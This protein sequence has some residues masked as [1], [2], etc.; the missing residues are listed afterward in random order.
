[1]ADVFVSYSSLDSAIAQA[2]SRSLEEEGFSVWR[3]DQ[4]RSGVQYDA[5]IEQE[6]IGATCVVVIWTQNSIFSKWVRAEATIADRNNKL[7]A[8]R[9]GNFEL[10]PPFVL[11]QAPVVEFGSIS[12]AS[13]AVWQSGI[14]TA[15]REL[16]S[17]SIS[18]EGSR[19]H[20]SGVAELSDGRLIM[21]NID[22]KREFRYDAYIAYG[23]EDR[24][25]VRSLLSAIRGRLVGWDRFQVNSSWLKRIVRP[26]KFVFLTRQSVFRAAYE[27]FARDYVLICKKMIV[28]CTPSTA[29]NRW[30]D[31]DI[32]L[33]CQV[34]GP[35]DIIPV[36]FQGKPLSG[37][38]DECIPKRLRFQ[39]D[40]NG[41]I[42]K[43]PHRPFVIDLRLMERE[44]IKLLSAALNAEALS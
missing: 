13:Q 16:V 2:V 4:L 36:V 10:P 32:D 33:F 28:I 27:N 43:V 9:S 3:D 42:S 20:R 17:E 7:V 38:A 40:A 18:D 14:V 35:H 25:H 19:L 5:K 21:K 34:R 23:S 41:N 30:L 29:D 26:S 11:D 6:L 44:Q 8:L 15:I 39:V 37:G 1:M 22:R 24:P 12:L 31:H